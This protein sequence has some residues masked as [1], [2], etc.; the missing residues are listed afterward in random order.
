[1]SLSPTVGSTAYEERGDTEL[2]YSRIFDA[3][4]SLV[5]AAH[6]DP[7]H[8]PQWLL[9]PDG[10]SMPICEID[11]RPG[12]KWRYVW[13]NNSD[14]AEFSMHGTYLE[15]EAPRRVVFT[16]QMDD[17]PGVTNN[18]VTLDEVDGKTTMTGVIEYPSAEVRQIV[19]DTGMTGGMDT[20]YDRLDS[21]LPS[22]A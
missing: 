20:S 19:L 11:L 7:K 12:G 16:E 13:R 6:T 14:G 1:M 22:L 17:N 9:G 3:P 10:W 15:V 21:L 18:T 4:A 8:V 2:V 5:F